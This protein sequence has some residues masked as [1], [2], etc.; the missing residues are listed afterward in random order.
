MA[1]WWM[2]KKDIK[3][4]PIQPEYPRIDLKD[5]PPASAALY[6]GSGPYLTEK[7]G[8]VQGGYPFNRPPFHASLILA[9]G[10]HLNQGKTAEIKELKEE[11]RSTRRI[12]VIVYNELSTIN[13]TVICEWAKGKQGTPYDVPG[14]LYFGFRIWRPWDWA[15]FCSEQVAMAFE[16]IGYRVSEKS[17][18]WTPP[19]GLWHWANGAGPK[20]SRFTLWQGSDYQG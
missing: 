11:F 2:L 6:Y 1:G 10:K 3:G 9:G 14:F 12:D 18:K 8:R 16:L 20:A 7:C 19:W 17:S 5:I 13:R 15:D 4:L